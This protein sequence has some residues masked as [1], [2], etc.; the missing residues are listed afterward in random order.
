MRKLNLLVLLW[1]AL[2]LGATTTLVIPAAWGMANTVSQETSEKRPDRAI[3]D[4]MIGNWNVDYAIYDE[5]GNVKHYLGTARY[6]WIL[7]G[8]AIQEIWTSDYH[9]RKRQPYGTTIEFY[10]GTRHCWTAM[11]IF[12][13]KGMYYSLSGGETDGSILLLGR[14]QEGVLQR[15]STGD[16]RQDSFVGR[17]EI[18]KDGGKT[19]RLV[20]INH[21]Y[22]MKSTG[23]SDK[24][25]EKR[26]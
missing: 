18:S 16:F 23:M 12:P 26:T 2:S 14:D 17:F 10:D 25:H 13:E 21:M 24:P 11:W 9:G 20:G 6:H 7:D 19:W 4:R 22:R 15:W 8:A 1:P 5:H 3:L